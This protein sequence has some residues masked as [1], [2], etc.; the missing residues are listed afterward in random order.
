MGG[1][2]APYHEDAFSAP[3]ED[4]P[5]VEHK[6]VGGFVKNL[7]DD[8]TSFV[9]GIPAAF[10]TAWGAGSQLV[11]DDK[12]VQ[13]LY[14]HPEYLSK[15]LANTW[16]TVVK[17]FTDTYKDGV[18][19]ALYKHPFS[20]FMDA[21]TVAD[22]VG[23]GIKAAGRAAMSGLEREALEA[24]RA[25]G[26][27]GEHIVQLGDRV[28]RFPGDML[29][30][31]FQAAG[32]LALKVPQV[33]TFAE[34]LGL[35]PL[36]F[37]ENN[38]MK[39][40]LLNGQVG[41]AQRM[42]EVF[43]SSIPKGM[44]D[45]YWQIRDGYL[46]PEFASDPKLAQRANEWRQ[47]NLDNENWMIQSGSKTAEELAQ[48][49]LKPLAQR[50]YNE[51]IARG[52]PIGSLLNPDG[53]MSADWLQKAEAWKNGQN[54]WGKPTTPSYHPFFG[55]RSMD[56]AEIFGA[57]QSDANMTQYV[58]RLER[59]GLFGSTIHTDPDLVEA[60]AEL[61][62][63]H[64]RSM[65]DYMSDSTFRLGKEVKLGGAVPDGFKLMDPLL[66][67]YVTDG[68]INANHLLSVHFADELR[69]L[70]SG[71]KSML[72]G[73]KDAYAKTGKALDEMGSWK[74]LRDEAANP[75]AWQ[76]AI[77]NE[78]A[79]LLESQLKGVTGPLRFYDKLLN[80]WRNVT[81]RLMPR[82]Y[83][84]QLLGHSALLLFGSHLPFIKSMARDEK[85]LPAEALSSAGIQLDAGYQNDLLS[86]TPGMKSLTSFTNAVNEQTGSIPRQLLV[87]TKGEELLNQQA[88]IGNTAALAM[89][90][91]NSAEE[92]NALMWQARKEMQTLGG[93]QLLAAKGFADSGEMGKLES[94]MSGERKPVFTPEQ[95]T[96]LTNFDQQ[97]KDIQLQIQKEEALSNATQKAPGE[98]TQSDQRVIN[99][100]TQAQM[101]LEQ[102]EK[103][104]PLGRADWVKS[105]MPHLQELQDLSARREYLAPRAE[106]GDRA[107]Q[108]MEQF[109][110][111]YGR[112]HPMES[113]IVR[114]IIPFWTFQKT[115]GKLLLN[116]PIVSPKTAFLWN[117]YAKLMI[118]SAN[119]DRLPDRFRNAIPIGH[120]ENPDGDADTIFMK[121]DGFS[122]FRDVGMT[123]FGGQAIPRQLDP[124]QNPLIKLG[125]ESMGGYDNFTEKPF[126]QPTDFVTLNGAVWRFSPERAELKQVVPQKPIID[127]LLNQLPHLKVVMEALDSFDKT[128]PIA[129]AI[130]RFAQGKTVTP[131]NAEGDYQYNR[132]WWWGASRAFGFPV[133]V[134]NPERV[135]MMHNNMVQ[136]MIQRY[137][138][139]MHRVD[140][141]TQAKLEHILE[142]LGSGAW[143][144][145]EWG[146]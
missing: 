47:M 138:G 77:P 108:M 113:Q 45:E 130:S 88:A 72:D 135:E 114:R 40:M 5:V 129:N 18:G 123:S 73:F 28:Q 27:I 131:Q 144:L 101:I 14:N 136:N 79:Y 26:G 68:L 87:N 76:V 93:K 83:I 36:G 15:E 74:A 125:V 65:V 13:D 122:P 58:Q 63:S 41:A 102:R 57:M 116:L 44:R 11:G 20:V 48:G 134:S 29:K 115:M 16:T 24:G 109:L 117:Q 107:V 105:D 62:I 84:N 3:Y 60:R 33:R 90:A 12:W 53:S 118:D 112:M 9:S 121:I 92:A 17:S 75:A 95:Q 6:S 54:P 71:G 100:K 146:D 30:A 2:V 67:K 140:P 31:P 70:S 43:E 22:I 120:S 56:M 133:H 51:A 38:R 52:E 23:G 119:D 42:D 7:G 81:L 132:Q 139:E 32:D 49:E 104:Q 127:S 50:L 94:M 89:K 91:G 143:K 69:G 8:I 82:F 66:K 98:V 124:M 1:S 141:E 55:E 61:Q 35:T 59:K 46:P 78:V 37:S 4:P 145:K 34:S 39:S 111:N 19:E 137:Y 85:I 106:L 128:R 142:D 110:G 64:L 21:T 97:L 86:H 103:L 25:T 96:Q 80:T 126:T 10:K 99:L